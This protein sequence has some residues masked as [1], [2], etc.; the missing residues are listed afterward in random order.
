MAGITLQTAQTQ[1]DLWLA[2]SAAVAAG[3]SYTI[4]NRTLTRVNAE[5]ILKYIDYWQ[6]KV[7]S[8]SDGGISG[9]RIR[10]ITPV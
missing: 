9:I 5:H 3:Q 6:R 1:L 8:L 4:G 2:A 10:G 7:D